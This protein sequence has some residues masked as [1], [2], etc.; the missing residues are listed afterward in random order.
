MS[1]A[2]KL[3]T[4][5]ENQTKVYEAGK[6][7]GYDECLSVIEKTLN[8]VPDYVTTEAK[9]VADKVIANRT[10]RKSVV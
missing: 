2:E 7:A 10:D 4:I 5:A 9:A 8:V 6:K 1:I 3:T